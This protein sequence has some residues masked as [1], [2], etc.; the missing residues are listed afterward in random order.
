MLLVTKTRNVRGPL[1]GALNP[2]MESTMWVGKDGPMS[3]AGIVQH[4]YGPTR[5]WAEIGATGAMCRCGA[6]IEA[7]GGLQGGLGQDVAS[8]GRGSPSPHRR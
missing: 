8:S 3:E 5:R 7:Q 1:S 4:M 6:D 2:P